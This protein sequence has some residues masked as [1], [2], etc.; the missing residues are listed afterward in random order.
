[1][2]VLRSA[3][4]LTLCVGEGDK[5]LRFDLYEAK[6]L[7]KRTELQAVLFRLAEA[8]THL[9]SRLDVA[10]KQLHNAKQPATSTVTASFDLDSN[11]RKKVQKKIPRSA[12]M[13]VL[14]P[15]SKRRKAA[16]GVEFD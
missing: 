11:S 1:M 10:T 12:G 7:E 2:Q 14:N 13:S 8:A 4:K 3:I 6:A 5:A 9:G 16:H 15:G